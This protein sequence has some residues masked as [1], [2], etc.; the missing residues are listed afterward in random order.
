MFDL[1]PEIDLCRSAIKPV[2]ALG[3]QARTKS[4]EAPPIGRFGP[5]L[6]A[7]FRKMDK[8]Q[9]VRGR[10]PEN[11]HQWRKL[12]AALGLMAALHGDSR[13]AAFERDWGLALRWIRIGPDVVDGACAI[14]ALRFFL[15]NAR[16]PKTRGQYRRLIRDEMLLAAAAGPQAARFPVDRI[17]KNFADAFLC[18]RQFM[19][20]RPK[21][22]SSVTY[23]LH[24][25]APIDIHLQS[26]LFM[27][28][29]S[30]ITSPSSFSANQLCQIFEF[31]S[32]NGVLIPGRRELR[33]TLTLSAK[34]LSW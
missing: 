15:V 21:A 33:R 4:E 9:P 31:C 34:R 27:P 2:H 3:A 5:K 14:D 26:A 20:S 12:Q 25:D 32:R 6:R 28:G 23:F 13:D 18:I 29:Y 22:A 8:H 10:F 1:P 24:D 7:E 19:N 11:P 17:A 30:S 16:S